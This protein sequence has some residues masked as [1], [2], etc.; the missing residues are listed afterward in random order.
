MDSM[1]FYIAAAALLVI[2]LIKDRK[3]TKKAVVKSLKSFIGL[4]PQMTFIF[5]MMGISLALLTP[6][7]IS[8]IIGGESGL[9]GYAAALTIGSITLIPSF[10]A[11]PLGA[12]LVENGA[13]LSQVAGF[14]SALMGVG[15][16]TFPVEKT[17]FGK[18]FALYRNVG[19]LIVTILFVLLVRLVFGGNQ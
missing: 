12:T 11:I 2:S 4:L 17:Y 8:G 18:K 10:I 5:V 1:I 3:E 6:E 7:T 16:M 15:I 9:L 14:I 19:S 13:G